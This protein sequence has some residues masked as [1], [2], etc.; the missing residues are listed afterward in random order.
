MHLDTNAGE[1]H[2]KGGGLQLKR[3]YVAV[4]VNGGFFQNPKRWNMPAIQGTIVLCDGEHGY[5][6]AYMDSIEITI[7]RTGATTAA[8]AKALARADTH[9]VTICGCGRQGRIQLIGMAYA[10]PISH[11]FAFDA[12]KAIAAAFASEMARELSIDVEPAATLDTAARQSDAIVTCT[13]SRFPFLMCRS[14]CVAE[15]SWRPS[16]QTALTSKSSIRGS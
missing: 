15:R 6:L 3:V 7:N 9:T 1:F 4:K 12:D 11:A 5:P 13:P 16:G 8:A 2:I 14:T 10:R